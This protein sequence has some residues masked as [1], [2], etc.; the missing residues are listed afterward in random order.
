MWR[1]GAGDGDEDDS[2]I[3][4]DQQPESLKEREKSA[5]RASASTREAC[6]RLLMLAFGCR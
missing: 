3:F 2:E 4:E 5:L 6:R 1:C